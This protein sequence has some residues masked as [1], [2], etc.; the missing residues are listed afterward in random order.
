[1]RSNREII[2]KVTEKVK[3]QKWKSLIKQDCTI[4]VTSAPKTAVSPKLQLDYWLLIRHYEIRHPDY[5]RDC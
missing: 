4:N 3:K 5:M 2:I 1:M